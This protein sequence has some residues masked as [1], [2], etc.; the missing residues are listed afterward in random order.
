MTIRD[1]IEIL[2]QENKKSKIVFEYEG[3]DLEI[4][5]WSIQSTDKLVIIKLQEK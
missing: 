2:Q 3:I 5:E 4:D 1:L